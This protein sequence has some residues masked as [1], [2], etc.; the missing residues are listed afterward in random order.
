[1]RNRAR[2][3]RLFEDSG[4]ECSRRGQLTALSQGPTVPDVTVANREQRLDLVL[5]RQ[6]ETLV[7][8]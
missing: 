6:R 5:A 7:Y 1:L 3:I 8:E 4:D 2:P